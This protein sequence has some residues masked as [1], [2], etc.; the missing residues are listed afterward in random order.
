MSDIALPGPATRSRVVRGLAVALAASVLLL[1][2]AFA[3]THIIGALY[4]VPKLER[5]LS[6][7]HRDPVLLDALREQN[8]ALADKDEAW[9]L[10]LDRAW[11][12]ER[13]QGETKLQRSI[14]EKPS[15]LHLRDIVSGSGGLVTHAFLIDAK[16]RMAA[17]PF[18]SFNFWQFDKP[19]FHYTF[20]LGAGARDVSWL[21]SS[22]DGK[23]PV[24]WRAE[25]MVDP[26]SGAP[27][28]V[29]ALEV[30]YLKVGHFGCIEEPAH[31]PDERR[32]NHVKL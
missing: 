32:T 17:E 25:T 29:V 5:L 27:I 4:Y 22:W 1:G 19:K 9:A 20:P 3:S 16:G 13:I 14:M 6:E 30:N 31:T 15:S 10:A 26:R 8:A 23:N 2:A 18:P 11:N 24:C 28:G 7:L 21:Q 12:A